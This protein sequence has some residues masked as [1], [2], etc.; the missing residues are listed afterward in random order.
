[1]E[2]DEIFDKYRAWKP[3]YRYG[4]ILAIGVI[5]AINTWQ[6]SGDT[7]HERKAALDGEVDN[8]KRKF[9]VARQKAAELPAREAKLNEIEGEL[10]KAKEF[11]PD[12]I[13]ID[14]ILAIIGGLEKE[15]DVTLV[16]F[17][18]GSE[19]M[20]NG[21]TEYKEMPVELEMRG[22]FV[23][24]MRFMDR[25]VHMQNLTHLRNIDFKSIEST[26]EEEKKKTEL[27]PPVAKKLQSTAKLI[28]FK[29][30]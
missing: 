23:N 11:L 30:V 29:G 15:L 13:E 7:L 1:M 25:L 21:S 6:S 9:E 22:T 26:S 24:T 10:V 2:L 4:L 14:N 12:K 28:L 18:P 3:Q 16:N 20:G 19:Q 17:K 27:G 5:P 8:E